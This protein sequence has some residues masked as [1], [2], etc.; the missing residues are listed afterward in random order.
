[1]PDSHESSRRVAVARRAPTAHGYPTQA[2]AQ[3]REREHVATATWPVRAALSRGLD[4]RAGTGGPERA[5][6]ARAAQ[7][8]RAQ[9][10][11]SAVRE[12]RNSLL[13][14]GFRET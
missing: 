1:M 14:A 6:P 3:R 13:T 12:V 11:P 10:G 5:G 8:G 2:A 7:H 9:H 4:G